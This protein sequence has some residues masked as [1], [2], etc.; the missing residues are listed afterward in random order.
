MIVYNPR[1]GI[2]RGN[3][4]R[5]FRNSFRNVGSDCSLDSNGV[6]FAELLICK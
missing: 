3:D 4:C 5:R 2:F 6:R 1:I